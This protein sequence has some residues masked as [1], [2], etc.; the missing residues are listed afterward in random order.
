MLPPGLYLF[1]VLRCLT[2]YIDSTDLSGSEWH[3]SHKQDHLVCF[4][5]G[6]LLLGAVDSTGSGQQTARQRADQEA[7]EELIRGCMETHRTA[8]RVLFIIIF[9]TSLLRG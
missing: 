4:L 3:I 6:S 9:L 8:T 7:G 5:G 1:F 2:H